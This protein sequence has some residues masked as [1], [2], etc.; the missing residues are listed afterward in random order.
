MAKFMKIRIHNIVRVQVFGNSAK[1]TNY[2]GDMTVKCF[3][4]LSSE[5][6][7]EDFSNVCLQVGKNSTISE[8]CVDLQIKYL[9]GKKK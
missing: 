3:S 6:S 8:Q 2:Q 5:F 9:K 7:Y 1:L 4:V